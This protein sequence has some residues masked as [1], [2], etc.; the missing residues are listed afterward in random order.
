M[1]L[2]S[3]GHHV[4]E[5]AR[6]SSMSPA[7]HANY[8]H[9]IQMQ[10]TCFDI[11]SSEQQQSGGDGRRRPPAP[12]PRHRQRLCQSL[13]TMTL[14]SMACP[15]VAGTRG[16]GTPHTCGEVGTLCAGRSL[17]APAISGS[18]W[19]VRSHHWRAS[20]P[21]TQLPQLPSRPALAAV[22]ANATQCARMVNEAPDERWA[23]PHAMCTVLN[24]ASG[25]LRRQR[26]SRSLFPD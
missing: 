5:S 3:V 18:M 19:A 2:L 13:Q 14:L 15:E 23:Q 22:I 6:L 26:P 24:R 21:A 1:H 25:A 10:L 20:P 17:Y 8:M 16:S 11:A 7:T 9:D 12:P 4:P